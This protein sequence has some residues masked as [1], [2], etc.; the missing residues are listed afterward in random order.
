MKANQEL[1]H[2]FSC[3]QCKYWWAVGSKS[4][5]V[6]QFLYCTNCGY[7]NRIDAI[8]TSRNTPNSSGDTLLAP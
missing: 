2:H 4:F 8:D 1:L 6:G 5:E 7:L 3:D